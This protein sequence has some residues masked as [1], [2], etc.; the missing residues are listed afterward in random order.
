[1]G[2]YSSMRRANPRMAGMEICEITPVILGGD[3]VASENK[4]LLTRQQHFE[5]V[6]YWN[7]IIRDLRKQGP[8]Q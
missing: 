2:D 8:S 1:M 3:P 4:T 6:R 7:R 5:M